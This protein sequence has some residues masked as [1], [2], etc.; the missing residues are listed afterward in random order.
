MPEEFDS[1]GTRGGVLRLAAELGRFQAT[2]QLYNWP[3]GVSKRGQP[4]VRGLRPLSFGGHGGELHGREGGDLVGMGKPR[5]RTQPAR[6]APPSPGRAHLHR[7]GRVRGNPHRHRSLHPRAGERSRLPEA[8]RKPLGDPPL[9]PSHVP[10]MRNPLPHR[11]EALGSVLSKC[12]GCSR[13]RT[14]PAS[15]STRSG[16]RGFDPAPSRRVRKARDE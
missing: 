14:R 5:A 9:R 2:V 11:S 15:R 6:R 3:P 13:R 1:V 4:Q 8:G 16:D 7:A 10:R 12:P